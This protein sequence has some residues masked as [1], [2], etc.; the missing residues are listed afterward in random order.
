MAP[1]V[2]EKSAWKPLAVLAEP[3]VLNL[4]ASCPTAVFWSPDVFK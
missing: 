3:P 4:S 1:V 2:L